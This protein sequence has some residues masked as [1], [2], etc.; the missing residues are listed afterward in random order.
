MPGIG[1]T[2]YFDNYDKIV[3]VKIVPLAHTNI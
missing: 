2:L 3:K 1:I